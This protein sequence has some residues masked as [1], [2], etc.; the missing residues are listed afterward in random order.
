VPARRRTTGVTLLLFV[1]AALLA[2]CTV[3]PSQRP[4]VAVRGE[5]MPPPPSAAPPAPAPPALPEPDPASSSL[6]FRDCPGG[7]GALAPPT[8][9]DRTLAVACTQLTVEADPAQPGLGRTRIGLVRVGLAD[10]PP[11][12][13]PLLVIGDSN[14]RPSAPVALALAGKAPLA[15]LQRYTLIGLDRRGSGVD[16]LECG[17]VTARNAIIN[18]DPAGFGTAVRLSALLEQARSV[19]QDCYLVHAG[20]LSG[21]RTASTVADVEQARLGLGVDRLSAVGIGDGASALALWSRAHPDAV[22]R[23]VLDGPPDPTLNE[24]DAS[25][26]RAAAAEITFD[27]FAAACAAGPDCP[28]GADP[29]AVVSSFVGRLRAQP[30]ASADGRRLTA[31][32]TVTAILIGLGNPDGWP[33]LAT[34][35]GAAQ[36]GEPTAVI[37]RVAPLLSDGGG[38]DVALATG[39]NDVQRRLTPD[40]VAELTERWRELYPLFGATTAQ[41]L[42][43]C[44]PWPTAA[45]AVLPDPGTALPPTLLI[46]IAHDPRGPLE[47]TRRLAGTTP[48]ALFLSW[49]GSGTGAFPRTPCVT[50]AVTAMLVDGTMPIDGTLCPP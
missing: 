17:P 24:P 38:L 5:N 41:R 30:L 19:V 25:E 31:G 29:R 47:A 4:P 2:G 28:L 49:Q 39:C 37:N 48:Q 1:V 10:A 14:T 8:L 21:F 22:A 26:A 50:G 15:L 45:P 36:G 3:G 13:P 7:R 27:A 46:G 12:R 42:L 16:E 33:D 34:A 9:A 23:L 32:M 44:A 40:E 11:D 20:A 6:E 35:L 43:L 18:I